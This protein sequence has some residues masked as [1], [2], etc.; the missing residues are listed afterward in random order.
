MVIIVPYILIKKENIQS[1]QVFA[2]MVLLYAYRLYGVIFFSFGL[3]VLTQGSVVFNRIKEL[4]M[5][6]D[7]ENLKCTPSFTER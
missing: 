5:L 4:L 2:C 6:E 3:R 7:V 1:E